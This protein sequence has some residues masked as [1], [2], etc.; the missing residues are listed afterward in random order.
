MT[1]PPTDGPAA[2]QSATAR[3]P[4]AG[5]LAVTPR[6]DGLGVEVTGLAIGSF[7][8]ATG[9]RLRELLHEHKLV[10]L[11]DQHPS[12]EQAL[13]FARCLGTPEPYFQDNYHHPR[14]PEVFVSSNIPMEGRKVGVAGTGRMWHHDY[15]FR[16]V[17]LAY[18]IIWPV[19]LPEGQRG[20]EFVDMQRA[21]AELPDDLR[22]ALA[23]RTCFHDAWDYYKVR[24]EDVDR[25]LG[26]LIAAFHEAA[27]GAHHPAVITHPV[28]G[29]ACLYL[30]SGFTKAVDGLPREQGDQLLERV[31]A[32]LEQPER[33]HSVPWRAGDVILWDNRAVIHQA[34][35]VSHGE[36]ACSYRISVRD[37]LPLSAD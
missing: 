5:S 18:T 13:H 29:R 27:P 17:V 14:H 23:G 28:T 19:V 36:P 30:S 3:S 2:D 11:P 9:A 22:Q 16:E 20:T 12:E 37:E 1:P 33:V 34:A 21:W 26:E 4:T 25:G 8:A 6:P 35:N 7:D 10:V 24:P 32:F 15:S 31:F